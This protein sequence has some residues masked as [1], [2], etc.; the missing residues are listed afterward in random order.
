MPSTN[1]PAGVCPH[2]IVDGAARAIEFYS[3]AFGAKEVRRVPA[4]DGKRL[5]HAEITIGPSTI[6]LCDDFP[7]FRG[8]VSCNPRSL[9][10][11]AA[12][13]HQYVPDC[14][15]AFQRAVEAGGKA[16]MPPQDQFW[17]DRYAQVEDP[18][19]HIWSLGTPL[20]K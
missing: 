2:L 5:M 3:K 12:V 13:L 4:Q 17:G 8:G 14:D 9:G 10:G 6:Y 11:C 20:A 15:R 16:L 7:E 19:G 1:H 18:F